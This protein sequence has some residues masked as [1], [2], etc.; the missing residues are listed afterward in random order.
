MGRSGCS[1]R[2]QPTDAL[3]RLRS[4]GI[5]RAGRPARRIE[6]SV[7][8]PPPAMTEIGIGRLIQAAVGLAR[9][10]GAVLTNRAGCSANARSRVTR[11]AAAHA[12][13][14]R[15]CGDTIPPTGNVIRSQIE[16]IA[17]GI[18]ADLDS[19]RSPPATAP[20]GLTAKAG[21]YLLRSLA[22]AW[23]TAWPQMWWLCWP[24]RPSYCR[25][26]RKGP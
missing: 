17:T 12:E 20:E 23:P 10:T 24:D 2:D 26:C 6:R 1:R 3:G 16:A 13:T 21:V 18:H 9:G 5:Y 14:S 15:L 4:S 25:A 22:M 11:R 19:L 8:L 7:R